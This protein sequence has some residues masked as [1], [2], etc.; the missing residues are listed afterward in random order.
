MNVNVNDLKTTRSAGASRRIAAYFCARTIDGQR[1]LLERSYRLRY[2]VYC[3]ERKF[4]NA[5]DYPDGLEIDRFDAQA[6][7]IGAIDVH[8]ELAGTARV[9]RP[10][11]LGLPIFEHCE[12][13]P[14]QTFNRCN[15]RLVEVGRLSVSRGY[16]RRHDDAL[17]AGTAGAVR[18]AAGYRGAESRRHHEDVFLTL[19]KGLYQASKRLGATHW[20][21]ATEKSLQRLLA[22]RGFPFH[23]IG[24]Q[25][26]YFGPVAPYQMDL[27]EFEN[28]VL[29][30]R[31]PALED[32]LD[33][34]DAVR[35]AAEAC[36]DD[37]FV[38]SGG[39]SHPAPVDAV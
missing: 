30:G 13:V 32:F 15:P 34:V 27:Q 17:L 2:Q 25:G 23:Q 38:R 36:D 24:P 9:V 31:F 14:H 22:L 11:D 26:D 18:P 20:L 33:G 16:Q 29:S 35:P 4:L 6:L 28:V 8:G 21:A 37:A 10:S 5:R 12:I 19:L 7:H 3:L 1:M 39:G